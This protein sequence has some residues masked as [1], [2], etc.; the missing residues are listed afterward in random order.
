MLEAYRAEGDRI[1]S[2]LA[3]R[4]G[5]EEAED[6]FHDVLARALGD[7][8][9]LEPVRDLAAWLWRS[10]RNAA[11]D[12]WRKGRRRRR[13]GEEP[14][15]DAP[16]LVEEAIAEAYGDAPDELERRE[17][18]A[19]LARAIGELPPAQREVVE[20]QVLRGETFRSISERLGV[21]IDTLA[22]RKRYA[23][24]RLGKALEDWAGE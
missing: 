1:R 24:A 19:A 10:A 4:M 17:L 11:I 15:A 22:A 6:A 23:L 5:A 9:A 18:L 8:D 2:W 14:D 20:A 3:A 7:M 12:A 13:L 21:P 16:G